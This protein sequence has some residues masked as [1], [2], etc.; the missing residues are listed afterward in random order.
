VRKEVYNLEF[1]SECPE[2]TIF[3]YRF[4]RVDDYKDKIASLQHLI[5]SYSEFEIHAN[6]GKHAVT[7]YVEIPE[8]E[9]EAALAWAYSSETA[10]S[11][12]LLLLSIFTR[13]DVFMVDNAI[14]DGTGKVI[15]AD[16]RFYPCGSVL[17]ASV[18]HFEECLNKV[19]ALLRTEKWKH[20]YQRGYFLFLAQQAFRSRSPDIAFILCWIIWEHLFAVLNRNRLSDE[21]IEKQGAFK[22]IAFLLVEYVLKGKVDNPTRE[23][24]EPWRNMRN[25]LIHFGRFHGSSGNAPKHESSDSSGQGWL[26]DAILFIELT[27]FI[28]TKTLG[29]S[30]SN[31]LNTMEK[32]EDFLK[33]KSE[34]K[35]GK[36][37]K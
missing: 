27:E 19:Y 26:Y 36:H 8:R 4:T 13:R 25:N 35:R 18:P 24:L 15:I 10:L 20:K 5:T 29:L 22:K 28:I 14:D 33:R 17:A 1:S 7:A 11:D 16:P 31:A 37:G 6:T 32:L 12:I 3:G 30:P 9:K 2:M 34:S 23:Q 21:E